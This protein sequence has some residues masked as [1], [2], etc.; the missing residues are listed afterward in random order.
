M[1]VSSLTPQE[2]LTRSR[3]NRIDASL[4]RVLQMLTQ[5]PI[6]VDAIEKRILVAKDNANAIVSL[7]EKKG[8]DYD[9]D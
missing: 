8:D 9:W 7:I 5:S 1:I 6:P 4:D 3:A 2:V